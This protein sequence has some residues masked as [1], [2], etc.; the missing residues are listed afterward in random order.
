MTQNKTV[1]EFVEKI[2]DLVQPDSVMWIDGSEAQLD[3]LRAESVISMPIFAKGEPIGP[4]ENGM[5]YIVRP[6]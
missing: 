6:L 3:E 4:I 2:K 5:M 1:L